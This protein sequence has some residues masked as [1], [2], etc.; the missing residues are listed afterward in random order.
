MSSMKIISILTIIVCPA[1]CD[2]VA[3]QTG[4]S[5]VADSLLLLPAHL[6]TLQARQETLNER[7]EIP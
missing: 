3:Q 4:S 1:D 5:A 2:T 6:R 7:I